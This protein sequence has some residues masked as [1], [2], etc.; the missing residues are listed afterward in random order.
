MGVIQMARMH[1][2]EALLSAPIA[3]HRPTLLLYLPAPA[4]A[5][6]SSLAPLLASTP[7]RPAQQQPTCS[8]SQRNRSSPG[9]KKLMKLVSTGSSCFS[10]GVSSAGAN[11]MALLILRHSWKNTASKPTRRRVLWSNSRLLRD[12]QA[13]RAGHLVM[14]L[15]GGSAPA[16]CDKVPWHGSL[17]HER[18]ERSG[19]I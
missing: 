2:V 13:D 12:F 17:A 6:F 3:H 19:L 14:R 18:V 7:S 16:R 9:P 5:F 11:D 8:C 10:D 1:I 4:L 15:K